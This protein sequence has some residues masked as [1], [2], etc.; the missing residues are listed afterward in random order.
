L[1][2]FIAP[3]VSVDCVSGEI[4]ELDPPEAPYVL[5]KPEE[6]GDSWS[7]E[8]DLDDKR[9]LD[10]YFY[11]KE[12]LRDLLGFITFAVGGKLHTIKLEGVSD[13]GVTFVAPRN[14]LMVAVTNNVFD[15]ILAGNFM[16]TV[17]HDI[18]SLYSPNFN[19]TVGKFADN[20]GAETKAEIKAYLAKYRSRSGTVDWALHRMVSEGGALFR[21]YVSKDSKL[22][23]LAR[24]TY[25]KVLRA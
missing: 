13:R 24:D 3:F 18:D 23:T 8:L 4:I 12:G 19:Y 10:D 11:R 20:G 6:F 16:Q 22:Y 1:A 9:V 14:S 2:D 25:M 5:H 7:D 21:R 15:D 17:L